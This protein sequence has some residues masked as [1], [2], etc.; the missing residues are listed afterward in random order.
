MHNYVDNPEFWDDKYNNSGDK[1]DLGTPVPV[2]VSLLNEKR[3]IRE[4]MSLLVSGCG[5]GYDAIAAARVGLTVTAVDFSEKAIGIAKNNAQDENLSIQFLQEDF[6]LLDESYNGSFD[7]IFEYTTFCAINPERRAEYAE[8][9]SRLLK[10]GGRLIAIVFPIDNRPGGPPFSID[11]KEFYTLFSR[12][13]KLEYF[14]RE[15]NSVK[16]RKGKEV[17]MIFVRQ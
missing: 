9:I 14:S 16:P 5:K 1:W 2:F 4:G 8:K 13:L 10:P 6:F 12:H 3:W 7:L 15:S 11:M 17:L